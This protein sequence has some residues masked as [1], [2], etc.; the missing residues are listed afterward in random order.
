MIAST[1]QYRGLSYGDVD[2]D[3]T[4]ELVSCK[5]DGG[6]LLW[7]RG[8]NVWQTLPGPTT[9]GTYY[10]TALG[11][12]NNDGKPDIVAAG[13]SDLGVRVYSHVCGPAA[14]SWQTSVVTRT[15]RSMPWPWVS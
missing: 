14:C 7:E 12:V 1:G 13:D 11:D 6:I 15:G 4:Q 8:P 10:D 2:G 3:G 9:S 5:W